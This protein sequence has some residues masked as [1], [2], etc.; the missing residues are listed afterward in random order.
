MLPGEREPEPEPELEPEPEAP[1]PR[2]AKG[3]CSHLGDDDRQATSLLLRAGERAQRAS[4]TAH[5]RIIRSPTAATA[6]HV[7]TCGQRYDKT[8][9]LTH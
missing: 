6:T 2:R 5:R 1:K 7:E 8:A 4:Q 3:E 9:V